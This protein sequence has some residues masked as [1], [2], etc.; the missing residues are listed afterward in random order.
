[1]Q[2]RRARPPARGAVLSAVLGLAVLP[3]LIPRARGRASGRPAVDAVVGRARGRAAAAGPARRHGVV[4]DTTALTGPDVRGW[5]VDGVTGET[6]DAGSVARPAVALHPPDIGDGPPRLDTRD[7]RR[8][9]RAV[10]PGDRTGATL[11]AMLDVIEA[12]HTAVNAGDARR[13]CAVYRRRSGRRPAR[14]RSGADCWS[15]GWGTRPSGCSRC[16]GSAAMT[17][18]SSSRTR[19]GS[20]RAPATHGARPGRDGVRGRGRPHL[21]GAAPHRPRRRAGC[22]RPHLT[23]DEVTPRAGRVGPWP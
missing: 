2:V 1:M 23:D 15:A 5:W 7:R 6:V 12:W 14:R 20:T 18:L 9:P 16:G 11:R 17:G 3:S 22:P 10:P 21:P 8:D 4:V 13:G 19:A